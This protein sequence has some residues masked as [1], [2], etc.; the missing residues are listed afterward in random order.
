MVMYLFTTVGRGCY[1]MCWKPE[2]QFGKWILSFQ[3]LVSSGNQMQASRPE[4]QAPS[5][6]EPS[7]QHCHLIG[8]FS[9]S[10][11]GK[12]ELNYMVVPLPAGLLGHW[13]PG[14]TPELLGRRVSHGTSIAN[15]F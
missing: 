7:H 15:K 2:E 12:S 13:L 14:L 10:F 9:T 5:P 1:S 8:C 3:L 4:Q 11:Q 6:R